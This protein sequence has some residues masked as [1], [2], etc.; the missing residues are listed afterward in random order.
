[1]PKYK[2]KILQVREKRKMRD[3]EIKDKIGECGV[4][5]CVCLFSE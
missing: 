4:C 5:E 3:L 2:T 1:M